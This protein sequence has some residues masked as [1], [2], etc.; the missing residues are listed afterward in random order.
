[1]VAVLANSGYQHVDDA[2]TDNL[3]V[4]VKLSKSLNGASTGTDAHSRFV[5]TGTFRFYPCLLSL[6]H[7]RGDV[8]AFF[9]GHNRRGYKLKQPKYLACSVP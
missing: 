1:M 3:P 2:M 8:M 4:M 7:G 9:P 5:K 6:F